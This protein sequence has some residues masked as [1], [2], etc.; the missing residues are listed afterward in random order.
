MATMMRATNK[1]RAMST[2]IEGFDLAGK[3]K[4]TCDV[5]DEWDLLG[6]RKAEIMAFCKRYCE[7]KFLTLPVEARKALYR[8]GI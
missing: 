7:R 1:C 8:R 3:E 6:R 5:R 2:T 4:G